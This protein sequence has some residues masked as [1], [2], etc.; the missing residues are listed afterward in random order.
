MYYR[1]LAVKSFVY[2]GADIISKA[3]GFLTF[4]L[5]ASVIAP[6]EFGKL[7][8]LLS[9]TM[10]LGIVQNCGLNNS[11]QRFYWDVGNDSISQSQIVS[12]GLFSLASFGFAIVLFCTPI[13]TLVTG[14]NTSIGLHI[15]GWTIVAGLSSMVLNQIIQ[16]ILDVTRLHFAAW[17]YFFLAS[18]ARVGSVLAGAVAV[19]TYG[20]GVQGILI[21]EA[22]VLACCLPIG[23]FLIRNDLSY[24]AINL[25]WIKELI[26]FGHPFI[27]AGLAFWML[28]SMD[29]WML[30]SLSGV[31]EVGIYSVALRFSSIVMFVSTAFG[32]AWSPMAFKIREEK[33]GSY[34]AIYGHVLLLIWAV[35]LIGA[36]FISLF[37]GE[38][39]A[40]TMPR[41]Y[42]ASA[43][44]LIILCFTVVI[45]ATQQVTAIGIS[46]EKK[47]RLLAYL[48]WL[49]ASVNLLGNWLL[50]PH[51]GPSGAAWATLFS[52]ILMTSGYIYYTQRLHPLK[53]NR[54]RL[55]RLMVLTLVALL[56]ALN[57][58]TYSVELYN[59]LVKL[60]VFCILLAICWRIVPL[61]T[62]DNLI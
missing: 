13:I 12:S 60:L 17:H 36:L 21:S 24:K 2:A 4:P 48:A 59:V 26:S 1:D 3:A 40:L 15:S 23:L 10:F 46:L 50:I 33:P 25:R 52:Q 22:L 54:L 31:A 14:A 49:A 41:E 43:N 5:V 19:V 8:L 9:I 51:F 55:V 62:Q 47:T 53:L 45:Q 29:R 44:P 35:V 58:V 39:I 56:I 11:V 34:R 16:Y 57:S 42:Y 7:E 20:L 38:F 6:S 27:S 37:A 18:L 28:L 30:V 32:Q 61:H